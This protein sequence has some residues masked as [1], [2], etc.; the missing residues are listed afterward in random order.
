MTFLMTATP[1]SMHKHSGFSLEATKLVIQ[2]HIVAMYLPALVFAW[3]Y[4]RLGYKGLLWA[5]IVTYLLCIVIAMIDTD[6]LHFWLA[7]VLVG[8]GWNFLFLSGTNLLAKGYRSK[9]RFRVQSVN[10]FIVFSI[11]ALASLASGWVLFQWQWSGVLWAWIPLILGFAVL[12]WL[13]RKDPCSEK[14]A[15]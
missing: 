14:E 15:A 8:V 2:S 10:D 12:L 4:D 11:Q 6:F 5:G 3:L 9:E 13:Y 7:L 1:I